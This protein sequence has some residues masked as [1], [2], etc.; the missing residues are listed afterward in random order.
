MPGL[1]RWLA[2]CCAAL[3]A[4]GAVGVAT[5]RGPGAPAGRPAGTTVPAAPAGT[6]P[7]PTTTLGPVAGSAALSA[8]LI[9]PGDLGG[10]YTADPGAAAA[11]LA[12]APCLAGLEPSPSQAG[13][14]ATALLGPGAH[15]LPAV[16]ELAASYSG[17]EPAAIY[18]QV[19]AAV[20]A[21]PAFGLGFGGAT[22]SVP[23]TPSALPPV[24]VA[25]SAWAGMVP[26][27]GSNLAVQ[28]AVVLDGH[29]VL[30]LLRLGPGPVPA[31]G[32]G[33]FAAALATAVGK[34]G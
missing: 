1:H 20:S 18:Q 13:R 25:D 22:L 27:A 10:H 32:S 17:R 16:V 23:L 28:L 26:F 29:T 14:A 5:H 4:A 11:V 34:L 9:G 31:A 21:C 30:G 8:R 33:G 2:S 12:S 19:V 3:L 24:G 15:S 7:V 6:T